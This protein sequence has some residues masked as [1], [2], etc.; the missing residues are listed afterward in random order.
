MRQPKYLVGSIAGALWMLVWVG[1]PLLRSSTRFRMV[2]LE[3]VP[4]EH[5]AA[6]HL[7]VALVVSLAML[8]P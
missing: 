3:L 8:L 1:R 2:G 6:V 5:R 7:V 4:D